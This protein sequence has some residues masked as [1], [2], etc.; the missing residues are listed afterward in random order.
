[1][2]EQ[3]P[4]PQRPLW[5]R[6]LASLILVLGLVYIGNPTGG[7]MELLLDNLPVIGN[8]DEGLAAYVI[9]MALRYLGVRIPGIGERRE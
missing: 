1:M 4:P 3:T 9:M 8:L 5:A 6:I 7:V 2:T